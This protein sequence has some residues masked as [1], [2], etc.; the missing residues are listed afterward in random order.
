MESQGSGGAGLPPWNNPHFFTEAGL[1]DA[2]EYF[3][4]THASNSRL[5]A[6]GRAAQGFLKG[7][8]RRKLNKEMGEDFKM[9]TGSAIGT[10]Q[11]SEDSKG[12]RGELNDILE[13]VYIRIAPSLPITSPIQEDVTILGHPLGA[14]EVV[15]DMS[16]FYTDLNKK[17]ASLASDRRKLLKSVLDEEL[18]KWVWRMFYGLIMS[19]PSQPPDFNSKISSS[20]IACVPAEKQQYDSFKKIEEVGLFLLGSSLN[21]SHLRFPLCFYFVNFLRQIQYRVMPLVDRRKLEAIYN[22]MRVRKLDEPI[23]DVLTTIDF[24][25]NTKGNSM[26]AFDDVLKDEER[27]AKNYVA[28]AEIDYID[29]AQEFTNKTF[30]ASMSK[31]VPKVSKSEIIDGEGVS[32]IPL[33]FLMRTLPYAVSEKI[34]ENLAGPFLS[35]IRNRLSYGGDDDVSKVLVDRVDEMIEVRQKK[36]ESYTITGSSKGGTAR[37]LSKDLSPAAG[38]QLPSAKEEAQPESTEGPAPA[39]EAPAEEQGDAAAPEAAKKGSGAIGQLMRERLIL[40]WWEQNGS[41]QVAS[42]APAEI[43]SLVGLDVRFLVPWVLFAIK[44]GQVIKLPPD[45]ISKEILER[46]LKAMLKGTENPREAR[47]TGDERQQLYRGG[48]GKPPNRFLLE[49]VE[50]YQVGTT[51][52]TEAGSLAGGIVSLADKMGGKLTDFVNNP[53]QETYA[54]IAKELS[55]AE[56]NALTVLNK[57]ARA[58]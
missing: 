2:Q 11:G 9:Y 58:P 38:G 42:I 13:M 26:Q 20:G 40:S 36:G 56:K 35:M 53:T 24:L 47:L 25:M 19:N 16:C 1:R 15:F 48:K 6:E 7:H 31:F 43:V 52:L 51:D 12:I 39:A 5:I 44:S 10:A 18:F 22:Q 8:V 30:A 33:L 17:Y 50:K 3:F 37:T 49:L 29:R 57:V 14:L 46:I 28:P 32:L 54:K 27:T 23:E 34:L 55:A 4:Q 41:L 21:Q 45:K